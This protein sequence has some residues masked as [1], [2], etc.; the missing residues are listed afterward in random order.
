MTDVDTSVDHIIDPSSMCLNQHTLATILKDLIAMG[1]PTSTQSQ[2]QGQSQ[3][4]TTTTTVELNNDIALKYAAASLSIRTMANTLLKSLVREQSMSK[5]ETQCSWRDKLPFSP[6]MWRAS[7]CTLLNDLNLMAD[8]SQ[9]L[10]TMMIGTQVN[11]TDLI[12]CASILTLTIE[13]LLGDIITWRILFEYRN[14]SN[15]SSTTT[16][17]KPTTPPVIPMGRMLRDILEDPVLQR[18]IGPELLWTLRVIIGPPIGMNLRNVLWHG[19]ISPGELDLSMV[20]L[21][22]VILHSMIIQVQTWHPQ[23]Q[24]L[25]PKKQ[26][27]LSQLPKL[28]RVQQD[29]DQAMAQSQQTRVKLTPKQLHDIGRLIDCS[30]FV[31]SGRQHLWHHAL[32]LYNQSLVET[33]QSQTQTHLDYFTFIILLPQLEHSLRCQFVKINGLS[34]RFLHADYLSYYT[35]L[36]LF[37][38]DRLALSQSSQHQQLQICLTTTSVASTQGSSSPA[39]KKYYKYHDPKYSKLGQSQDVETEESEESEELEESVIEFRNQLIDSVGQS[40][41]LGLLDLFLYPD[42]PRIR[43]RI[44]HGEIDNKHIPSF[45]LDQLFQTAVTLLVKSIPAKQL[46][47]LNLDPTIIPMVNNEYKVLFHPKAMAHEKLVQLDRTTSALRQ[48]LGELKAKAV[49]PAIIDCPA[50]ENE[51]LYEYVMSNSQ[52]SLDSLMTNMYKELKSSTTMTE[53][54]IT[55]CN[56]SA[57]EVSY[58]ESIRKTASTCIKLVA[59]FQQCGQQLYNEV[60]VNQIKSKRVQNSFYKWWGL[61]NGFARFSRIVQWLLVVQIVRPAPSTTDNMDIHVDQKQPKTIG[62]YNDKLMSQMEKLSI[63]MKN[64]AWELMSENIT[65]IGASQLSSLM[66]H[67]VQV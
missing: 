52:F 5:V 21:M 43:D 36:D 3:Q 54:T 45:I 66:R 40:N 42:G 1:L 67:M 30:P 35:T 63:K 10:T 12:L 48:Y 60:I 41:I 32:Q 29:R 34:P 47:T 62:S 51:R 65:A 57:L 11:D 50:T 28:I 13:R 25:I 64:S 27:D 33:D 14:N 38:T 26:L 18:S 55:V 16:T 44:S 24:A 61:A 46:A 4:Q 9:R 37:L 56:P 2:A 31:V 53:A 58:Y 7:Q 6:A 49:E 15:T 20:I 23:P 59:E 39:L 8:V 17:S 19:F 22:L